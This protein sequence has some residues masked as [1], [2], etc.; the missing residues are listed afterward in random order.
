[1]KTK[2]RIFEALIL[3]FSLALSS[4]TKAQ[5]IDSAQDPQIESHAKAFLNVLNAG[6]G[7]PIE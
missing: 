2:Q 4:V 5:Q 1:M 6:K 3:G 7:K